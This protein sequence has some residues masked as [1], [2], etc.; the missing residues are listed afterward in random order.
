MAT[1]VEYRMEFE[2]SK[3]AIVVQGVLGGTG[4][5]SIIDKRLSAKEKKDFDC[6]Y[7]VFDE[8][9]AMAHELVVCDHKADSE[10]E[11]VS[12]CKGE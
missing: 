5:V 1:T 4:A 11:T 12:K 9:N 7:G 2:R 3:K 6:L 8:F 10:A